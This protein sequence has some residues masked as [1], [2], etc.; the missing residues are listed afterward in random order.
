MK[1]TKSPM[2][3]SISCPTAE[4]TGTADSKIARARTSS[5]KAQRSSR[6]PPPRPT[7][8]TSTFPTRFRSAMAAAI[9]WL[10]GAHLQ[11]GGHVQRGDVDLLDLDTALDA[12]DAEVVAVGP[13]DQEGE[14]VLVRDVGRRG[15]QDPVDGVALDVHAEDRARLLDGL[16]GVLGELDA[17]GLAATT[18]LHLRLDDHPAA[19]LLRGGSRVLRLLHDGAEVHRHVVLGEELLRLVLHQ[20]HG[21]DRPLPGLY[22]LRARSARGGSRLTLAP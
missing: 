13:V 6:D 16:V 21:Y 7:I 18:G 2:V 17:A 8:M 15:D 14:V 3:K 4:T 5:L 11:V 22:G 19:V 1:A 10:P 12:R 20:V 9:S